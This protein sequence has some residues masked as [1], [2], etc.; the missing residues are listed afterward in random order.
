MEETSECQLRQVPR[1][2]AEIPEVEHGQKKKS[3]RES[4]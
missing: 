2:I 3:I 1:C 4:H